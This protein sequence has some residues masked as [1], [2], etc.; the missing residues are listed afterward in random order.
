MAVSR[1]RSN[2]VRNYEEF[3]KKF[4]PENFKKSKTDI[5]NN[6]EEVGKN[7]AIAT[8]KSFKCRLAKELRS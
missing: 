8:L 6:P 3:E 2:S 7:M 1:K 4:F 5:F